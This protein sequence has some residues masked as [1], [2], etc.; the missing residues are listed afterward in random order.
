MTAAMMPDYL[1]SSLA[2]ARGF[3]LPPPSTLASTDVPFDGSRLSTPRPT[4]VRQTRK[5]AL[6]TSPYP[7]SFDI[8]SMI[9]FSPNSLV[10]MIHGSRSS[11]ASAGSYG[12]LSAGHLSPAFGLHPGMST[13]HLQQLHQLMRSGSLPTSPAAFLSHPGMLTPFHHQTGMFIPPPFHM[14]PAVPAASAKN[15]PQGSPKVESSAI[16]S[17]TVDSS[18]EPTPP[19][20]AVKKKSSSSPKHRSS[21]HRRSSSPPSAPFPHF[22]SHAHATPSRSEADTPAGEKDEPDFQETN[23]HWKGCGREFMNP[24][25]LVKHINNDHIHANKKS[26]VCRWEHC[27]REEKPFK[28]QYMLV[29]HMR[30]HTGEKPHR[31]TRQSQAALSAVDMAT[32]SPDPRR[33]Y[34][35]YSRLENLKTHLRSHTGE[36]PYMCE[37]PGCT[38]AFSNASDRAKHQNRTHSNEKPYVCK[39]PDCTKRYTDPSSLRKHVKTVHGPDFYASKKHKG[40]DHPGYNPS[41]VTSRDGSMGGGHPS[42]STPM[43]EFAKTASVSSPSVKSE[44]ANSPGTPSGGA[45]GGGLGG[46]AGGGSGPEPMSDSLMGGGYHH[47]PISEN[48]VSTTVDA[49][50]EDEGLDLWS[51]NEATP[52]RVVEGGRGIGGGGGTMALSAPIPGPPSLAKRKGVK[53]GRM[54]VKG[55]TT[56]TFS[57]DRRMTDLLVTL[58]PHSPSDRR[59]TDLHRKIN[60]LRMT[61]AAAGAVASSAGARGKEGGPHSLSGPSRR[62]SSQSSSA[63][64]AY[65]SMRPSLCSRRSSENSQMSAPHRPLPPSSPAFDS[66]SPSASRRGSES[67]RLQ[68]SADYS[69]PSYLQTSSHLQRLQRRALGGGFGPSGNL[70]GQPQSAPQPHS[71]NG[72]SYAA[73]P[74]SRRA[75]DP[76][77]YNPSQ[78]PTPYPASQS[79]GEGY[80]LPP[81]AAHGA[82]LTRHNSYGDFSSYD[83]Y[84]SGLRSH[85]YG[86]NMGGATLQPINYSTQV[87]QQQQPRYPSM[88]G[89]HPQSTAYQYPSEPANTGMQPCADASN[90]SMPGYPQYPTGNAA[91]TTAGYPA[92]DQVRF[93]SPGLP[94]PPAYPSNNPASLNAQSAMP[95]SAALPTDGAEYYQQRNLP[96][97]QYAYPSAAGSTGPQQQASGYT[98][99]VN[100][101]AMYNMSTPT[102]PFPTE[103]QQAWTSPANPPQPGPFHCCGH[104]ALP[105]LPYQMY[106]QPCQSCQSRNCTP[107][108][109]A[110]YRA[111]VQQQWVNNVPPET[112]ENMVFASQP[113]N[114]E[115]V[116]ASAVPAAAD[117]TGGAPM[118]S[119]AYQRT[120]EYVQ[121]CQQWRQ[122]Q[123]G[124]PKAD[125]AREATQQIPKP[126]DQINPEVPVAPPPGNMIVADMNGSLN[127][128]S[129]ENRYWQMMQ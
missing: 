38:K 18:D 92:R 99:P 76:V 93:A 105:N 64:S 120:L 81:T 66:G 129:E 55:T 53:G 49:L 113:V 69:T 63:S 84:A 101:P 59:M 127:A 114:R 23:C 91:E 95:Q 12:H 71:S 73:G 77:G 128:L 75:S 6:S 88:G 79:R 26:F 124:P 14:P 22:L 9:R 107:V 33:C 52:R 108:P 31:C 117:S 116:Q 45:E 112:R 8:N 68:P 47:Q 19:G 82:R 115:T 61:G 83:A 109:S 50:E 1:S 30:R 39:A 36:K 29:V 34:K 2:A 90:R 72:S 125:A 17:S 32:V 21:S 104:P 24:D 70:V 56:T 86:Q 42:P 16:V 3:D 123:G 5:R 46:A 119:D 51:E 48:H 122:Q 60:D 43:S 118:R 4:S 27:C 13:G 103:P 20:D 111:S 35:A 54:A 80:S 62:G 65:G 121:Q 25:D 126:P 106:R 85:G 57:N 58:S 74:P 28:A 89:P 78:Y 41:S 96:P 87:A 44:E 98:A 11:S 15:E 40:N 97:T 67:S 102:T 100:N 7:D 37:F 94:P 110:N 10:S